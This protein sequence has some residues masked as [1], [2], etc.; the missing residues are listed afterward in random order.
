MKPSILYINN[1]SL[2]GGAE[3]ALAGYTEAAELVG[4]SPVVILPE[5][6]WLSEYCE[7][8]GILVE[9][10]P[11]L[12]G[13]HGEGWYRQFRPW[14]ANAV[15]IRRLAKKYHSVLIHSN[16]LQTAFH[17]GLGARLAHIPNIT[18]LHD[19]A[20][21]DS[22]GAIKG[23][24]LASLSDQ[25]LCASRALQQVVIRLNPRLAPRT[26]VVYNGT[27]EDYASIEPTDL[28][29]EFNVPQNCQWIGVIGTVRPLKG[30]GVALNAFAQVAAQFPHTN[31]IVVGDPRGSVEGEAYLAELRSFV[32][33]V[34]LENRVF[35]AGWRLDALNILAA[36]QILIHTPVEFDTL[37]TVLLHASALK[38]PI[39]ASR[40]GGIPEIIQDHVSGLLVEPGNEAAA[41]DAIR[42]F[43]NDPPLALRLGEAA[44]LRNRELFSRQK[45]LDN[46]AGT[47]NNLLGKERG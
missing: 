20:K 47:Y 27:Q 42:T 15:K 12:P 32:V 11:S 9:Y 17:G 18:H 1:T 37:P 26:C 19:N 34:G 35:F 45:M 30:Q 6:G 36:L 8:K 13:I 10:M 22:S 7:R 43:L 16:K 23:F 2:Q 14:L 44:S 3:E 40:V 31:L 21:M 5:P 24:L 33:R 29:K 28:C 4:C 39:I 41:A 46:L 25:I 38:K